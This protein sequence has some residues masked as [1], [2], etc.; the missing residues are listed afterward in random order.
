[1]HTHT[2][3]RAHA[4]TC[5]R[6]CMHNTQCLEA[7]T[8]MLQAHASVSAKDKDGEILLRAVTAAGT[9]MHE[10]KE[11]RTSAPCHRRRNHSS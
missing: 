3:A 6:M 5:I 11:A 8:E 7:L 10:D 1:M 9:L 4:C 2:H